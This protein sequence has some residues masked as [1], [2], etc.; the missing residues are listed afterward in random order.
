MIAEQWAEFVGEDGLVAAPVELLV[1]LGVFEAQPAQAHATIV[2]AVAVEVDH[3]VGLAAATGA[4]QLFTQ[5][6]ECGRPEDV[7]L[8]QPAQGLHGADQPQG[9]GPVID[10]AAGLVF[11]PGR[12]QQDADGRIDYGHIQNARARQA[13]TDPCGLCSLE[14]EAVAIAEQLPRQAQQQRGRLASPSFLGLLR[15]GNC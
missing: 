9:A 10:V 13:A 12:Y 15:A 3:M 4:V 6:A 2:D 1:V 7:Q 8:H 5:S 11:R 14:Q